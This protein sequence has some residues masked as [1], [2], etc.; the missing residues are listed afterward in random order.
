M[1]DLTSG[2]GGVVKGLL[3]I[4]AAASTLATEALAA[5]QVRVAQGE[6]RGADLP[7]G[8]GV[9]RGVPYAAAPV[10]PLRWRAPQDAPPWRGV[11]DAAV[12]G[13]SCP[14]PPFPGD[15]NAST[16]P[17]SEDCLFL[18]IWTPAATASAPRGKL[19]VL[20][21]IHGGGLTNGGGA[22][23]V[24]DGA[25]LARR[26]I[27]VVTIN[28][29]LGRLGFFAHP[30][31]EAEG[32]G[33]SG[34]NFAHMDQ[35]AALTWVKHN[36]R[37]F[38]GDPRRVTI[39]GE[40]AGGA[41]V[42]ALMISPQARGLFSAAIAQ[43]APARQV[44]ASKAAAIRAGE[45][46]ARSVGAP[47]DLE[48]LRRVP[49][50]QVLKGVTF[51]QQDPET[52]AGPTIDG[53]VIPESL[54]AAFAAGRQARVPYLLGST[55]LE[56]GALPEAYGEIGLKRLSPESQAAVLAAYDP[57]G[58][59]K[60]GAVAIDALSDI[61]F[62]EP[63]RAN[64]RAAAAF[65]QSVWIYRFEYVPEHER[66]STRGARHA[67]DVAYTF[68]TLGLVDPKATLRDLQA[69]HQVA[70]YWANFIRFHDPNGG[71]LPRWPR[72]AEAGEPILRMGAEAFLA[73]PDPRVAKL[74]VL[75]ALATPR[76]AAP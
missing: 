20:V 68:D 39:A 73:G 71:A 23:P 21:S 53:R 27:V 33:S 72:V 30:A 50:D 49:I 25:A 3:V 26:G 74:D 28:Y 22:W 31:L 13:P 1:L 65:G 54:M 59:R 2:A 57:K 69:A 4:L 36:I 35:I 17:F 62:A 76:P 7:G 63:A 51:F 32:R 66:A 12:F 16:G 34:V 56:L 15:P 10:G 11:R 29:R 37:A 44:F 48:A 55:G 60:P 46:F 38:G 67:S 18:N 8:G 19:P 14:Q 40:S 24:F 64:A 9:Y 42:Q 61:A 5:P 70:D 43:S 75:E 45:A 52:Y 47:N 6:L 58:E 41:S